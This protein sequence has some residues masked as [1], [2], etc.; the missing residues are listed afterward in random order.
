MSTSI[1][2]KLLISYSASLGIAVDERAADTLNGF[3][4]LV[5]EENAKYNLTAVIDPDGFTQKHLID[6]IAAADLFPENATV[7]DI[8]AG[9]GFPSVPLA[10]IRPDLQI[11]ALDSTEKKTRFIDYAA[12]TL[13]IKNISVRA[14]RAE[15][16]ADL[17]E[18]FDVVC[19]RAVAALPILLELGVPLLKKGGVF[20]AYKTDLSE[21]ESAWSAMKKLG[22]ENVNKKLFSLPSGDRRAVLVFKKTKPT[23]SCYPRRYSQIK[24]SPL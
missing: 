17:R 4:A 20:I 1:D 9:A 24:K 2:K 14:A 15:E 12:S 16:C 22:V 23:P 5:V 7:C 6:S 19:A 18:Q 11:T 3:Y 8:G 10:V 13:G 21:L